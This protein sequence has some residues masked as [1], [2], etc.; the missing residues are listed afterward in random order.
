MKKLKGY[1]FS[2]PFFNERVPQ[3]IQNIVLRDY[4]KKKKINFLLSA[5]E[6]QV[7][8]STYILRELLQN[9]K[10]FDGILFYSFLQL[11]EDKS[12]RHYL[13]NILKKNKKEIHFAVENLI[14]KKNNDYIKLE[15]LF[16][17][18]QSVSNKNIQHTK[19]K[20][21][22][23]KKLI[24]FNHKR[25]KRNYLE[26]MINNKVKCMKISKKYGKDY[27]DGDRQFGY[28]GYKYIEGYHKPLAKKLIKDYNLNNNSKILDIGC[29]KGFLLY[30]I[31]K[32]LKKISITGI[33]ISKYA[34][35][36]AFGEIRDNIII[37]FIHLIQLL[38]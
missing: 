18:K 3:H 13:F 7:K 31:K 29:G 10:N 11:P 8:K 38:S 16:L 34:K 1:I 26:R 35:K 27:W 32:I 30:E 4:S 24:T 37:K 20:I 6:Y 36:K 23:L 15:N 28:G 22:K 17:I 14:V 19:Y 21:G 5:T 25:T 33:D 12:E 2:R 9:I